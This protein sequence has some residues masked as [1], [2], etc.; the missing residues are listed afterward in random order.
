MSDPERL[1]QFA[2]FFFW[3]SWAAATNRPGDTISY[4]SNWPHEPLV[5]NRPT[6]EAV[7]WTGVSIIMLLA[8]IGAMV[9]WYAAQAGAA[10]SRRRCPTT[11]PLLGWSATP[12]Q[13]ATVKYFWVVSALIL[14][15]ILAG[16]GHR[17]LRRR[18]RRLLRHPALADGCPTASPGPG[19]CSS[20]IFWIAT[21]WLAAGLFI[22]PLV[23]GTSRRASGSA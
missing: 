14:V 18:R 21:A 20:G 3:T 11:D 10:A 6:G 19:T 9:W 15:Q 4:T 22:G 13:R 23:S 16:R 7:V 12:S 2:A 17:P 8:G 1:R 5:G